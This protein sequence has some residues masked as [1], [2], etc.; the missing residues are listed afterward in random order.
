MRERAALLWG[1]GVIG[2]TAVC[3]VSAAAA[4]LLHVQCKAKMVVV[5]ESYRGGCAV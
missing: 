3:C 5:V 1:G 2:R 4:Q